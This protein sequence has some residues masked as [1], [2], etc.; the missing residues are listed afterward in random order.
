MKWNVEMD[1][2]LLGSFELKV[3][4]MKDL[5]QCILNFKIYY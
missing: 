4:V 1:Y 5:W 3:V 2:G